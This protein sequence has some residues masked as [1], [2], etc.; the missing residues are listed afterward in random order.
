MVTFLKAGFGSGFSIL[1]KFRMLR[2]AWLVSKR[3]LRNSRAISTGLALGSPSLQGPW[4]LLVQTLNDGFPRRP[5]GTESLTLRLQGRG[6][7]LFSRNGRVVSI[8]RD[9]RDDPRPGLLGQ[10]GPQCISLTCCLIV[11]KSLNLSEAQE[12]PPYVLSSSSEV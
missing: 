6:R 5:H 7:G 1:K 3:G 12:H 8:L 10:S 4:R 11:G 2:T 9:K